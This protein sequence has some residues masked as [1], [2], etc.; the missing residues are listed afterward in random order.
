MIKID[1][2]KC[3]GCGTCESIEPQVFKVNDA[4]KADVISQEGDAAK[5]KEAIDSCPT[6]AIIQE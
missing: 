2:E 6:D 4:G 5:I 1:E 3:I